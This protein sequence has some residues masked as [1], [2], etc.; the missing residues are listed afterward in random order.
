MKTMKA[1]KKKAGR[2]MSKNGILHLSLLVVLGLDDWRVRLTFGVL[3]MIALHY[4][5]KGRPRGNPEGQPQRVVRKRHVQAQCKDFPIPECVYVYNT[6]DKYHSNMGCMH[7]MEAIERIYS[8][9]WNKKP[10]GCKR[11]TPCGTCVHN[12]Q[13]E[14]DWADE[15]QVI[16]ILNQ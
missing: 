10:T 14:K 16:E 12:F 9:T 7:T 13:V 4:G 2:V 15:C 3:I 6:S 11:L 8:N 5:A 1:M